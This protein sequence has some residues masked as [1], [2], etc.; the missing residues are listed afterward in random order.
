RDDLVT[1]VQTCALP[2]FA[3]DNFFLVRMTF[4]FLQKLD[5]F[6]GA[7]VGFAHEFLVTEF[8]E[9]FL[10]LRIEI[11]RSHTTVLT[12]HEREHNYE[13]ALCSTLNLL[14]R[15][16]FLESET[17]CSRAASKWSRSTNDYRR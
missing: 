8:I 7:R 5:V 4:I 12:D 16:I 2:I 15:D 11:C 10:I 6:V 13:P 1:G 3:R 14:F 17:R 9:R